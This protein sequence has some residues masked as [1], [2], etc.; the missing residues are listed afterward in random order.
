MAAEKLISSNDF[1]DLATVLLVAPRAFGKTQ[2]LARWT[3]HFNVYAGRP[4]EHSDPS[5]AIRFTLCPRGAIHRVATGQIE[6]YVVEVNDELIRVIDLPGEILNRNQVVVGGGESEAD[7]LQRQLRQRA[8]NIQGIIVF[9]MAPEGP[10]RRG[11]LNDPQALAAEGAEART[12]HEVYYHLHDSMEFI[13][14]CLPTMGRAPGN[15]PIAVQIGFCDLVF[16]GSG[17]EGRAGLG[18][19]ERTFS[20]LWP[21]TKNTPPFDPEAIRA[22]H[23]I[24]D[25]LRKSVPTLFQWLAHA[26][27]VDGGADLRPPLGAYQEFD[28]LYYPESNRGQEFARLGVHNP[29]FGLLYLADRIFGTP[30]VIA[31]E[32][33]RQDRARER[34]RSRRGF[35]AATAGLFTLG[36]CIAGVLLREVYLKLPHK[37]PDWMAVRS[38]QDFS[39]PTAT[40]CDCV[41][42]LAN[43]SYGETLAD[44]LKMLANYEEACWSTGHDLMTADPVLAT[45]VMRLALARALPQPQAFMR[46]RV[47]RAVQMG[48]R[49]ELGPA[50]APW[51]PASTKGEIAMMKWILSAMQGPSHPLEPVIR[52]L[53]DE[54]RG[55]Y[56]ALMPLL[57]AAASSKDCLAQWAAAREDG[58][59]PQAQAV[60]GAAAATLPRWLWACF[61]ADAPP[62]A[63]KE[64]KGHVQAATKAVRCDG[65]STCKTGPGL[66]ELLFHV[67]EADAFTFANLAAACQSADDFHHCLD[68]TKGLS[69]EHRLFLDLLGPVPFA[70]RSKAAL[71]LEQ[72]DLVAMVELLERPWVA[73]NGR[74]NERRMHGASGTARAKLRLPVLPMRDVVEAA[75]ALVADEPPVGA[76]GS[77]PL[78]WRA[79]ESFEPLDM[80]AAEIPRAQLA[81]RLLGE[82]ATHDLRW[83]GCQLTALMTL[84][85]AGDPN[86]QKRSLDMLEIPFSQIEK[87]PYEDIRSA[88][89]DLHCDVLARV[90]SEARLERFMERLSTRSDVDKTLGHR[91]IVRGIL[92]RF[93][94]R[95]STETLQALLGEDFPAD[96]R[97]ALTTLLALGDPPDGGRNTE[98]VAAALKGVRDHCTDTACAPALAAVAGTLQ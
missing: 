79:M 32:R 30:I 76:W 93:T 31:D 34:R 74:S 66:E 86:V 3:E 12:L 15:V 40:R 59:W 17:A 48:A 95:T 94:H 49:A 13:Q 62:A 91:C 75:C 51:Y 21:G 10:G 60:C 92:W 22:R 53:S 88:A 67:P 16:W 18:A 96:Y 1:R 84:S 83:A 46:D 63:A 20:A 45:A 27:D 54:D 39:V 56:T 35:L 50:S 25:S 61:L 81:Q 78:P 14:R 6:E 38:C 71:A 87:S 8:P 26:G 4:Q 98:A 33:A 69:R 7:R 97:D 29:A 90:P 23:A 9:T 82:A 68:K 24:Y 85:R 77:G 80:S 55:Q 89:F 41:R 44:R 11:F 42:I 5:E 28:V 19:M 58:S 65:E 47:T 52:A 57:T 73:L 37:L 72:S 36:L 64:R 43:V 70:E 2:T